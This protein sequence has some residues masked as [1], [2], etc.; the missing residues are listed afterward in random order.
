VFVAVPLPEN[1]RPENSPL[2]PKGQLAIA[3]AGGLSASRWAAANKVPTRTAQKWARDPKVRAEVERVRRRALDRAV[4]RMA[5]R[6]TWA[7]D[8]IVKLAGGAESE[9]VKLAALK[10]IFSNMM[11]VSKFG[12]LEDRMTE[13]EEQFG[14]RTGNTT[15]PV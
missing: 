10:A 12:G 1:P 9:S 4:G 7:T 13:L 2:S 8:G 15:H 3:I 6:V 14:D 5:R 11:A